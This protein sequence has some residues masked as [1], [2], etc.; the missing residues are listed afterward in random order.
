MLLRNTKYGKKWG[1]VGYFDEA[2][3]CSTMLN[4]DNG[5]PLMPD[6][7]KPKEE[8]KPVEVSEYNC[9]SCGKPLIWRKSDKGGKDGK[10]YSFYGCSGFPKCKQNYKEVDGKPVFD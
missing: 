9:K 7:N 6:P 4:N 5:K 3:K 10:G 1:C 2:N 8:K